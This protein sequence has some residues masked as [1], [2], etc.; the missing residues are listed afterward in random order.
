MNNNDKLSLSEKI[1]NISLSFSQP[2]YISYKCIRCE[3]VLS[4]FNK[5]EQ[6]KVENDGYCILC[7]PRYIIWSYDPITKTTTKNDQ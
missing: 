7:K 3:E 4:T 1:K 5:E 2:I 6:N